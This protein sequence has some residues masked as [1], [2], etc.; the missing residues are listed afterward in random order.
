[1]RVTEK[2]LLLER[3]EKYTK[4]ERMVGE[5]P[6]QAGDVGIGIQWK[7]DG[8]DTNLPIKRKGDR[9]DAR[10]GMFD[11]CPQEKGVALQELVFCQDGGLLRRERIQDGSAWTWSAVVIVSG[12]VTW[13]GDEVG[14][15]GGGACRAR[16]PERL[17]LVRQDMAAWCRIRRADGGFRV[18]LRQPCAKKRHRDRDV[19]RGLTS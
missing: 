15:L 9:V 10:L 2:N 5:G 4:G 19:F 7:T 16:C 14:V 12:R 18:G 13:S 6:K 3:E 17:E 8:S 1:M 11:V